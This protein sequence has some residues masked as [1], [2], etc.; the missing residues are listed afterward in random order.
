MKR[1]KKMLAILL[2]AILLVSL[3]AGCSGKPAGEN[4]GAPESGG[5]TKAAKET[6]DSGTG[7]GEAETFKLTVHS[8]AYQGDWN[9]YWLIKEIEKRFNVDIQVEMISNDV[10]GDKLPLM[11]ASDELPDFFLNSVSDADIATYGTEGYLLDL[12]SYINEEKTPT[13]WK[14]IEETPSLKAAIT[15]TDGKIYSICGADMQTRELAFNRFYINTVWAD[16]ILGKQPENLDEFYQYLKGVKENDMN[17]NGDPNDEIPLGGYYNQVPDTLDIFYPILAAFGFSR[18]DI[19]AIDG[20]A[21]WVPAEDNYQ[22]FLAYMNKLYAEGLLDPEYFTQTEDQSNAKETNHLYGAYCYY[23]CW[24]NQP[25]E[26]IW[27]EYDGLDPMISDYNSTQMWP[28]KD[29]NQCGNFIISKH[30]SNPEKLMEILDWL[31]TFEGGLS[32]NIGYELGTNAE[33]PDCGYTYEW[34][35]ENTLRAETFYPEDEYDSYLNF[36]YAE[37][38][39]DYGYFP[40]YRTFSEAQA[41]ESQKYLTANI[42]NHYAPYYHVGWP[43]TVKYT[44]EEADE[45]ALITTD[46]ESYT[47]EMVTKMVIGEISLDQFE[48]FREGLKTR[49]LDRLLEIH[50]AAY[51]RWAKTQE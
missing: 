39:P 22:P 3:A 23:A 12:S 2:A 1:A 25:D 43:S 9:N 33:R 28:A 47:D 42:V 37:V 46:I 51:D 50:Q 15:Q 40:M 34:L 29:F 18:R 20:K 32:T 36:A 44:A 13:I 5:E 6:E 11:F 19:E 35:D 14:A 27:R 16:Q 48:T 41:D 38:H 17:G 26:K 10:W 49:N 8:A 21:V 24:V 4:T 31:F 30:C 45:L 7:A